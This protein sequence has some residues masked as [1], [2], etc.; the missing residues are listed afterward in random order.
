MF[1]TL[2]LAKKHLQIDED[3]KE[4][5]NYIIGLIKVAEDAVAKNLDI[6]Q[7]NELMVDGELP[8]TIIQAILLLVGSLYANREPVSYSNT[9]KVPYS[10]EYLIDLYRHR[11]CP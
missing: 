7:L 11:R 3:F 4:D 5:D 9:V 8:P 6:T 10:F 1:V 2:S